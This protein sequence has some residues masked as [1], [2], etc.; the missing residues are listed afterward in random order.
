MECRMDRLDELSV[1]LAILEAGSL[2]AARRRLR[3]SPAA[4][5]RTLPVVA[6]EG[7]R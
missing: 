1:P 2:A 4:M 6:P 5:T 7:S 3:R